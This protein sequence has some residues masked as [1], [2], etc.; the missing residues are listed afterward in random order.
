ML[1]VVKYYRKKFH[2]KRL[3]GFWIRLCI[4]ITSSS[5]ELKLLEK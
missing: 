1:S 5:Y 3:T 4:Y 2:L